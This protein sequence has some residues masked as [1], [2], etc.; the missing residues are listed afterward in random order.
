MEGVDRA[1]LGSVLT[2]AGG[3]IVDV[4]GGK[5][6]RIEYDTESASFRWDAPEGLEVTEAY[7]FAW[8][9]HHPETEVWDETLLGQFPK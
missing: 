9:A 5:K 1:Y 3:R 2:K 8:K 7:W 4:V 6:I